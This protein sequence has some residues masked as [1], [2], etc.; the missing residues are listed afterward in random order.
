VV[1]RKKLPDADWLEAI[2]DLLIN[3][4]AGWFGVVVIVPNFGSLD[5]AHSILLLTEDLAAGIVSLIFAVKLKRLA[6]RKKYD[7]YLGS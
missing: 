7:K 2:A 5:D 4:A 6:K 3:L 1:F